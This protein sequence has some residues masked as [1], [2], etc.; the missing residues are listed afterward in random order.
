MPI[1]GEAA[2]GLSPED[3]RFNRAVRAGVRMFSHR[4]HLCG[5]DLDDLAQEIRIA[6]WQKGGQYPKRV[7]RQ[8]AIDWWRKAFG[9]EEG[10][11]KRNRGHLGREVFVGDLTDETRP[12]LQ[13]ASRTY[14]QIDIYRSV[15]RLPE[16][17]RSVIEG[18]SEGLSEAAAAER[19]GVPKW[20]VSKGGF[21]EQA[22]NLFRREF[23]GY[24]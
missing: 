17:Y 16:I 4:N 1:R 6:L 24:A 13:S 22:R 12:L 19:A 5:A 3:P 2:R 15:L 10:Q 7:A 11:S 9:L 23:G 14:L 18:L 8:R 21:G 20:K